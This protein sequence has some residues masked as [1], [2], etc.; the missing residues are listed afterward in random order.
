MKLPVAVWTDCDRIVGHVWTALTKG[1]DMMN[2]EERIT[3]SGK[4]RRGF[5]ASLANPLGN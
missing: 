3:V 2:F 4:K 1:S 5:F